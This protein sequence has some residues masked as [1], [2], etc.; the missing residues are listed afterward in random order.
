[1]GNRITEKTVVNQIMRWLKSLPH[2]RA[3][4]RRGGIANAGEPDIEGCICGFHFEIEA[5]SPSG[6]P[7]KLQ[8]EKLKMWGEAGA[9]HGVARSL[10]EAQ[11]IIYS[12]L[13]RRLLVNKNLT[14]VVEK[15]KHGTIEQRN[16]NL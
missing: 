15:I 6:R 1:M 12:G 4:K 2:C 5:K 9:I 8:L 7:T 13:L 10:E 14:Q 16:R 3:R 11:R